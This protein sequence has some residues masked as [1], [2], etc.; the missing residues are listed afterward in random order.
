M[1]LLN[2]FIRVWAFLLVIN[3]SVFLL[4]RDYYKRLIHEFKN[5]ALLHLLGIVL[6]FIGMLS[7]FGPDAGPMKW[8]IILIVFGWFSFAIGTTCI[9]SPE[10]AVK[11]AQKINPNS[12]WFTIAMIITLIA[13]IYLLGIAFITIP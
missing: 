6:I 1:D 5:P 7:F 13:G 12:I 9:I 11:K 10:T 3:A 8:R 4:D 2:S